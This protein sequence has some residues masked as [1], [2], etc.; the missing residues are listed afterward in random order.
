MIKSLNYM[1]FARFFCDVLRVHGKMNG[2]AQKSYP[3]AFRLRAY[4]EVA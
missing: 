4:K 2:E 1:S 3:Q